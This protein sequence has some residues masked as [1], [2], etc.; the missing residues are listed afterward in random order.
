MISGTGEITDTP[1]V[2][3]GAN[4][5]TVVGETANTGSRADSGIT[6]TATVTASTGITT[7]TSVTT[8]TA[9]TATADSAAIATGTPSCVD[10]ISDGGFEATGNWKV[11]NSRFPAARVTEPVYEGEYSLRLGVPNSSS[12]RWSHSSI[13]QLVELPSNATEITLYYWEWSEGSSDGGDY[14][15]VL[16]LNQFL[17]LV[18]TLSRDRSGGE[19]AWQQRSGLAARPLLYF[20]VYN[21]GIGTKLWSYLDNVAVVA[22]TPV[23]P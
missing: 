15:E 14:R 13:F 10:L 21:N 18:D 22:C 17:R 5:T 6:T 11:G 7:G 20:N 12:N 16:L 19:G 9:T 23:A 2:E 4:G 1:A 8:T 3:T